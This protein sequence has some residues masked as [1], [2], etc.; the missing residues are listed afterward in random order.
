MWLFVSMAIYVPEGAQILSTFVAA[1]VFNLVVFGAQLVVFTLIRPYF[2]V[3][4]EPHTYL[5]QPRYANLHI[6]YDEI[7]LRYSLRR[8]R[9]NLCSHGHS[10]YSALTTTPLYQS[11]VLMR[12]SLFAP[13]KPGLDL[14]TLGNIA[15]T[16]AI[17]RSFDTG[18]YLYLWVLSLW[19]VIFILNA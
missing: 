3:I 7:D 9:I 13:G 6:L 10:L 8:K 11:T 5:P 15:R 19:C 1:I 14:F 18:L 2:K 4:H 12:T 17:C 16:S